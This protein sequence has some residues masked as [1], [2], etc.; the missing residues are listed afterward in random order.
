LDNRSR[1]SIRAALLVFALATASRTPAQE[2]P[3][4]GPRFQF[5]PSLALGYSTTDNVNYL[6]SPTVETANDTSAQL[7]ANVPFERRFRTGTWDFE[8]LGYW[9]RYRDHSEL[10]N[11]AHYAETG[12]RFQPTRRSTLRVNGV[13]ALTQLQAV[14]RVNPDF[15]TGDALFVGERQ[16]AR[17]YGLGLGYHLGLGPTWSWD[18]N[19]SASTSNVHR[20]AGY[21][22]DAAA[23]PRQD[24]RAFQARTRFERERSGRFTLGGEYQYSRFDLIDSGLE[25]VHELSLVATRKFG[26]KSSIAGEIGAYR[27]SRAASDP[28][29]SYV[30]NGALLTVGYSYAPT[31]ALVARVAVGIVPS[32]GGTLQ[33]TST[34]RTFQA[35]LNGNHERHRVYW[36]LGGYH[37]V[38]EPSDETTPT[39]TILSLTGSIEHA[40]GTL[41]GMRLQTGWVDQSSD[42]EGYA[43]AQ[44][45]SASLSGVWY[46]LGR[47]RVAGG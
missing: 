30:Q 27:R 22:E 4:T 29:A 31:T 33:G 24:S 44:Y 10:D 45:Y 8:Y 42:V 36:E 47:S 28:T 35:F 38:R 46:P 16:T 21:E 6:D 37:G 13:Y 1:S 25:D 19:V 23:L 15:V 34:N 39:L 2:Q 3:E 32:A 26:R 18:T 7:T 17:A 11:G 12:F 5:N 14:A 41:F 40:I 20:I 9:T 43:Q